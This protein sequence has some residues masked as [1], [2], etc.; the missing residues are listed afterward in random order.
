MFSDPDDPIRRLQ[1]QKNVWRGIAI[2]LAATLVLLL[3][4][5]GIAGLFLVT[6]SHQARRAEQ[7]AMEAMQQQRD[8]AQRA[9]MEAQK[10]KGKL[11]AKLP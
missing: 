10:Q 5:G 4:L 2:G 9:K 1:H 7:A 3:V 8:L 6:R 11:P